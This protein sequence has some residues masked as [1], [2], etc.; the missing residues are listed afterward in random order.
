MSFAETLGEKGRKRARFYAYGA[1]LFGCVS[2]VMLDTSA[3]IILFI[4]MLGGNDMAMMA[5]NCFSGLLTMLCIIPCVMVISRI[6]LKIAVRY[7]CLTGCI[8]FLLMASAP[9]FGSYSCVAAIAGCFIYCLQRSLYGAAWYPLL[10]VFLRPEDRGK[11]F[12]T[13]R[14]MYYTFT[15]G[16]FFFIGLLMGKNPPV[17]LMQSVIGITGLLLVGRYLCIARFPD[18]P[19]AV[20]ENSNFRE[21]LRISIC[22]G[23]LTAYSV[24]LCLFSMSIT[25]IVPL[26]FIYLSK[27]VGVEPGQ[28]QMISAVSMA[29]SIAGFFLYSRLLRR[30]GIKKLEVAVHIF[31]IIAAATMFALDCRMPGFIYVVAGLLCLLAFFG[32]I[33]MCNN[34]G[35]LLALARPGNKTMATSFVQTYGS[36]GGFAGRG[37]VSLVLGATMLA[38]V[39]HLGEMEISRYQTIFLFS[40]VFTA[41]VLLL[42]PTLPSVVPKHEDYYEPDR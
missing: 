39:W 10:D 38:P 35:E 18:D 3:I 25:S 28:I 24:Y 37:G 17:W 11:F 32:S 27:Y 16:L 30:F 21:A 2:E 7:A 29:G 22:N 33:F 14:F 19:N 12:G 41:V 36:F 9:F 31:Y 1:C 6:G 23:P 13:L 4:Q 42:I 34:S 15:G 20:R 26:T 5:V 40:A 8:G